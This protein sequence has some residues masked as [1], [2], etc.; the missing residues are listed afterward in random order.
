MKRIA[1]LVLCLSMA[2]CFTKCSRPT[3]QDS[4]SINPDSVK[5]III[6]LNGEMMEAIKEKN[7]NKYQAL[8]VDS[9]LT[10]GD[11]MFMS[12]AYAL[13]HDLSA[14]IAVP[15]HDYTFRL[16]G[17][18]AILSYLSVSYEMVNGDSVFDSKRTLKTFV[19]D[20]GKWKMAAV[21]FGTRDVN[22]F[23]PVAEKH[24]KEYP[25]YAG[26]YQYDA[27]YADT[28]FVK[29]GKLYDAATGG[30]PDLNFPVSDS[31]YMTKGNL[32]KVVFGKDA[33]GRIAY[34]TEIRSDG[35]RWKLPKVK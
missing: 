34:Y 11:N 24:Q 27:Q 32:F 15:A 29:D 28:V 23:T 3:S 35:Q 20:S 14:G 30:K 31:E 25:Q 5:K 4:G 10:V 2:V 16:I 18:T 33:K 19:L 1:F 26:I 17:N 22:Y 7:P 12:S 8:C 21:A 6:T 13:S 9:L